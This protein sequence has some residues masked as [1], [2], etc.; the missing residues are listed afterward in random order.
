MYN[1]RTYAHSTTTSNTTEPNGEEYAPILESAPSGRSRSNNKR[2]LADAPRS[3]LQLCDDKKLPVWLHGDDAKIREDRAKAAAVVRGMS[4]FL[5]DKVTAAG[6][7]LLSSSVDGA[8]F[9]E[10]K[11]ISTMHRPSHESTAHNCTP[12]RTPP[13][14]AARPL[15][16]FPLHTCRMFRAHGRRIHGA[17]TALPVFAPS[18]TVAE[19][20]APTPL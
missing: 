15:M 4:K 19:S 1:T 9:V 12:R 11:L 2:K 20:L 10:R 7:S 17:D 13:L 5:K 16:S 8:Q 6:R 14:P 18:V 3:L